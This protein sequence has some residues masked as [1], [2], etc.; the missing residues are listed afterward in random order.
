MYTQSMAKLIHRNT[1][2]TYFG[3]LGPY[4]VRFLLG[5]IWRSCKVTAIQ[6]ENY[7]TPLISSNT[8]FIPAYWHQHQ[9]YGAYLMRRL[10]KQG[11]N[12]GFL[13]SASSDGDMAAKIPESWGMTVIRGSSTH[14]GARALRDLYQIVMKDK[15]SPVNTSDGPKGP[16]HVFKHG[17]ILLAQLTQAKLVPITFAAS[18]YWEA[19]S[20]DKLVV[21]K[22]FSKIVICIGEPVTIDKTLPKDEIEDKCELMSSLLINLQSTAQ[23]VL[24]G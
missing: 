5:I 20:W 23:K 10:K 14:T 16:P 12:I 6:G 1:L 2:K 3:G 19:R 24:K 7:L 13:V 17:A 18:S 9:I 15:V 4:L 8:P 22:P 11:A 21:P